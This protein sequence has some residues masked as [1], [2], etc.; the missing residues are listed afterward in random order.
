MPAVV[1]AQRIEARACALLAAV[2]DQTVPA[3]D[4]EE[5]ESPDEFIPSAGVDLAY[6][7]GLPPVFRNRDHDV[8]K[9]VKLRVLMTKSPD[10]LEPLR[11]GRVDRDRRAVVVADWRR[12]GDRS[13][14]TAATGV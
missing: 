7:P 13:R 1:R 10:H 3:P 5:L 11:V 9:R 2:G 8:I 4:V 12:Y 6:R 14:V